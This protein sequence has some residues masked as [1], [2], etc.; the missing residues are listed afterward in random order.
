MKAPVGTQGGL[1]FKS[2]SE[3]S[4]FLIREAL[5]S[6]VPWDEAGSY[7]RFSVTFE[8]DSPQ[9]EKEV[10]NE[11]KKRLKSLNLKF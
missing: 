6:T 1:T 3:F 4:G 7:V 11:M 10:I 9:R 2:A 5:I 8:A